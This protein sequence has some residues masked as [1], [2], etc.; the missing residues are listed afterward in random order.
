MIEKTELWLFENMLS[1]MN[2]LLCLQLQFYKLHSIMKAVL[3]CLHKSTLAVTMVL[4]EEEFK[5]ILGVGEGEWSSIC[6]SY[7]TCGA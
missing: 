5:L 3:Y 6:F 4:K 1:H 2:T 7:F